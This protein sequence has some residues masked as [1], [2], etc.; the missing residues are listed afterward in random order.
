[1]QIFFCMYIFLQTEEEGYQS[2]STEGPDRYLACVKGLSHKI[3]SVCTLR[4]FHR[5]K[6]KLKLLLA[7]V[8][9]KKTPLKRPSIIYM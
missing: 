6:L 3:S 2:S 8:K 7:S 1:M 9:H 5:D 4:C